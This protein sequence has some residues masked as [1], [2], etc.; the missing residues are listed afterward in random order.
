[1][2]LVLVLITALTLT[3]LTGCQTSS[4]TATTAP[5]IN[6][7][8]VGDAVASAAKLG[9]M[10]AIQSNPTTREYFR[11]AGLA[12][13]LVLLAGETSPEAVKTALGSLTT[14]PI[15]LEASADALQLYSDY[16]GQL[17]T[18]KLESQSPYIVPVLSGMARGFKRAYDL[19]AP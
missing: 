17:V 15:L 10:A 13:E 14:D 19:T 1:M 2:K 9:G 12:I 11:D 3:T 16:Y 5:K 7:Q 6:P 18:D 8:L 4:G